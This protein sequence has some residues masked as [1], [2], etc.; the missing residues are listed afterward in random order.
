MI[1]RHQSWKKSG[2]Q[3]G[4]NPCKSQQV[5]S[6]SSPGENDIATMEQNISAFPGSSL[7]FSSSETFFVKEK[8]N[9]VQRERR[10]S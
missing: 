9:G 8:R 10:V 2:G 6:A 4:N 5:I 3:R 1:R 7:H